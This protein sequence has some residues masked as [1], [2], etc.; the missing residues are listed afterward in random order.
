MKQTLLQTLQRPPARTARD[1]TVA[2][3]H[4]AALEEFSLHGYKGASTQ[5]IAKRAGL[6]KQQLHYYIKGKEALYEELLYAVLQGWSDTFDFDLLS[7]DPAQALA[8]YVRKKL[9]FALDQPELSR[10]FTNEVL[11]GGTNL[12]KYWP[13]AV[14]VTQRKVDVINRWIAKGLMRPL[15]AHVLLMQIWGITQHYA[16]Y[17]VQVR[18]MLGKT[19]DSPIEREPIARE[20]VQFVLLGCGLEHGPTSFESAVNKA[21]RQH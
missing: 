14:R 1:A 16:D 11:S 5:S 21:P 6:T 12:G 17:G 3:I 20:I 18:V 15:D 2:Q 9:D 13:I 4:Q 8:S 10:L 7:E 19:A